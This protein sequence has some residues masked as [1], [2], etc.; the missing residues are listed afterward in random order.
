MP[1][2]TIDASVIAA[3]PAN[4]EPEVV[5]Q[6]VETLLALRK[7]AQKAWVAIYMSEFTSEVLIEDGL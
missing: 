6:Y 1:S 4:T 3:P 7:L 5:H 2:M